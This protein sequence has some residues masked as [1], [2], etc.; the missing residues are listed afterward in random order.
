[1]AEDT[2][3]LADFLVDRRLGSQRGSLRLLRLLTRVV[4]TESVIAYYEEDHHDTR[5]AGRTGAG[6]DP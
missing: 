3:D 5:I 2:V 6:G 1:M 4:H